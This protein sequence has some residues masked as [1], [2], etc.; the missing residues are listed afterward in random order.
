[1]I[2]V[3]EK[4]RILDSNEKKN[5]NK[6]PIYFECSSCEVIVPIFLNT[7]RI[8]NIYSIPLRALLRLN[9]YLHEVGVIIR[10]C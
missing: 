9:G 6:T 3:K 8:Y 2:R 10:A 7:Y 5:P 4:K 1:M